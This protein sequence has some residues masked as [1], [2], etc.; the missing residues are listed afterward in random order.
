MNNIFI[1]ETSAQTCQPL[2]W[3][4]LLLG[5]IILAACATALNAPLLQAPV[6][7]NDL[8]FLHLDAPH[9]AAGTPWIQTDWIPPS[10]LPHPSS[11][12]VDLIMS[13][14]VGREDAA[15]LTRLLALFCHLAS[16]VLVW[17]LARQFRFGKAFLAAF[18]F[19]IHPLAGLSIFW[20]HRLDMVLALPLI[21][22]TSLFYLRFLRQAQAGGWFYQLAMT[23]TAVAALL[24]TPYAI[25]L[26]LILVV[27]GWWRTAEVTRKLPL[28][29]KAPATAGGSEND[30]DMN[31]N[32]LTEKRR[33]PDELERHE[34]EKLHPLVR[35]WVHFQGSTRRWLHHLGLSRPHLL[36]TPRASVLFYLLPILVIFVILAVP[37][38]TQYA[39]FETRVPE[40]AKLSP[41]PFP[42]KLLLIGWVSCWSHVLFPPGLAML[43][44]LLPP[45]ITG[46]LDGWLVLAAVALPVLLLLP[47]LTR[48]AWTHGLALL[49]SVSLCLLLP[50]FVI[51]PPQAEESL[52]L[53]DKIFYWVLPASAI[54]VAALFWAV[55]KWTAMVG[56]VLAVLLASVSISQL[57]ILRQTTD[58]RPILEQQ[59]PYTPFGITIRAKELA[60]RGIVTEA[61]ALYAQVLNIKQEYAPAWNGSAQLAFLQ[62]DYYLAEEKFAKALEHDPENPNYRLRLLETYRHWNPS[63]THQD[64]W[65]RMISDYP[66]EPEPH[67]R[68]AIFFLT[69]HMLAEALRHLDEAVAL[70]PE[71]PEYQAV[72]GL[73]HFAGDN[74]ELAR[75]DFQ[76]ALTR[77]P[78][79]PLARFGTAWMRTQDTD[80][81]T[82]KGVESPL[83][84]GDESRL[85]IA[86][87]IIRLQQLAA[88]GRRQDVEAAARKLSEEHP[89]DTFAQVA[90]ARILLLHP[91]HDIHSPQTAL[92]ILGRA[93]RT[94]AFKSAANG[95]VTLAIA[96]SSLGNQEAATESLLA[97]AKV[98]GVSKD[99]EQ[100]RLIQ[101]QL[102]LLQNGQRIEGSEKEMLPRADF[103]L[104]VLDEGPF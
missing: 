17:L 49:T 93:A 79:N 95:W 34:W 100:T 21:L 76:A 50:V 23:L 30:P 78:Q 66:G 104:Y 18:F 14:I 89:A 9:P 94:P 4:T 52:V 84:K 3:R 31:P 16:S 63:S 22:L 20:V 29:A 75:H 28:R 55:N 58:V 57:M 60:G 68:L 41:L 44:N 51:F 67:C 102:E 11:P 70:T 62:R 39:R 87:E 47:T 2:R 73:F 53:A 92:W 83:R 8:S 77:D 61:A 19:A 1:G 32:E 15:L 35:Q 82:E 64:S 97:A 71:N 99:A 103:L 88:E 6:I 25:S 36:R 86:G 54:L 46:N 13:Q 85:A 81:G 90:A 96:H 59:D 33:A 12:G 42:V 56:G 40:Y 43:G 37:Y 5:T 98:A 101:S 69:Q 74:H 91:N 45:I 48:T 24:L 72:R 7:G 65:E 38:F 27:I 80:G 26:P 10:R